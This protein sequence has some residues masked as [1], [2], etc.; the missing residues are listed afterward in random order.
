MLCTLAAAGELSVTSLVR[1]AVAYGL[2]TERGVY[3]CVKGPDSWAVEFDSSEP[4]E[5]CIEL[6]DQSQKS[7]W[8]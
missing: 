2:C 3:T 8:P 5:K 7:L 1:L 4:V 6:P